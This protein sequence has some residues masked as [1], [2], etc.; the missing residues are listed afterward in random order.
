MPMTS[1]TK[2]QILAGIG[3]LISAPLLYV[4]LM[5]EHSTLATVGFVIF[6]LSILITP[7]MKSLSSRFQ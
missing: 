3:M 5:G 7:M 6:A 2:I 1:Q 4:G